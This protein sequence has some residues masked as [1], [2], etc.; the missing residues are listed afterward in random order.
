MPS[1]KDRLAFR[2]LLGLIALPPQV[3]A[4]L[5]VLIIPDAETPLLD[6]D[7][8]NAVLGAGAHPLFL[9]LDL[10]P[11]SPDIHYK[12]EYQ[13]EP[14]QS[15][16]LWLELSS[17]PP[18]VK[19]F[20]FATGAVG[21]VLSPAIRQENGDEEWLISAPGE[22]RLTGVEASLLIEGEANGVASMRLTPT[23][24]GIDGVV[25][26]MLDPSMVLIGDTGFGIE[27]PSGI[28]IDQSTV[29]AGIGAL[30]PADG[31]D[32]RGTTVPL[33]RFYLP[34]GVPFIGGHAIDARFSIGESPTPGIDL[35]LSASVPATDTRPRIDI[36][37]ECHDPAATGLTGFVP[38]LVEA[39]MTLPLNGTDVEVSGQPL[40]LL[41]GEPVVARARFSRG[42][43]D[44]KG[45]TRISLAVEGQ[46]PD[47]LLS[48]NAANGGAAAKGMVAVSALATAI[49]ADAKVGHDGVNGG[50]TFFALIGFGAG[51]QGLA[52]FLE[53]RG[54]RFVL[55]SAELE[56]QGPGLP[57]GGA[58]RFI[59]D[60]TASMAIKEF[61]LGPLGIKPDTNRPLRIRVR[62]V[63]LAINIAQ[64]GLKQFELDFDRAD[65][66]IEDPGGWQVTGLDDL[67]DILGT[68]GGRGSMWLEVDLGFKLN[69]G[70][71]KVSGATIRATLGEDGEVSATIRGLDVSLDVAR[72]IEGHGALALTD[73]GFRAALAA[74]IRPLNGLGASASLEY[75]PPMVNLA[76]GVDLPGPI[77]IANTGLGLYGLGGVFSVN[78]KPNVDAGNIDSQLLWNP[79]MEGAFSQD[80]G[81]FTFGIELV[82]GTAPDLG[83][84]FSA[85]GGIFLTLPDI[86]V[87][88][89]LDGRVMRPRA[90]I[91]ER[92]EPDPQGLSLRGVIAVD[93]A[94][95]VTFALKGAYKVP[96]I[97]SA[98]VPIAARF[99]FD[100]ADNWFIYIGSDGF[101]DG[102]GRGVGP[103]RIEILPDIMPVRADG[104]LMLRG[105]GMPFW[106]R[107]KGAP[108]GGDGFALAFG[109]S[110]LTSVGIRPIVWVEMHASADIRIGTRPLVLAGFGEAGGSLNLGPFSIGVDARLSFVIA[111]DAK[112]YF[113]AQLCGHI[114]LFFFDVEGCVAISINNEPPLTLAPPSL[115]PLDRLEGD[116]VTGHLGLL[117]DD[118][119]TTVAKLATDTASAPTV[120][121]DTLIHFAFAVTPELDPAFHIDQFPGAEKYPEGVRPLP[122]GSEMMQY[123]WHLTNLVLLDVTDNPEGTPVPGSFA[124]AWQYGKSGDAGK[125]CEA[126]ELVL[127]TPRRDLWIDKLADAGEGL[128]HDPIVSEANIC[129]GEEVPLAGW[130][131]GFGS[132][133]IPDGFH[134]P[135]DQQSINPLQSIFSADAFPGYSAW[136]GVPLD[137][138]SVQD[139]A[140]PF[141]F[142]PPRL[143]DLRPPPP[144]EERNFHAV[145]YPGFVGL[146]DLEGGMQMPPRMRLDITLTDRISAGR[147]WI[148]SNISLQDA[149][150][151]PCVVQD[152]RVRSFWEITDEKA[153]GEG[154]FA[155]RFAQRRQGEFTKLLIEWAPN[156]EV[157]VLGIGGITATARAAATARNAARAAE[158]A[159]RAA[160]AD[161]HPP[162]PDAP[163]S[164]L[165]RC[166]L[167]PGKVYRVDIDLQWTGS[168]SRQNDMG[169][170][171]TVH[172]INELQAAYKPSGPDGPDVPTLRRFFFRTAPVPTVHAG[173]GAAA[174]ILP[175]YLTETW[176]SAIYRKQDLFDPQMLSRHLLGYEPEQTETARFRKDPLRAHFAVAHVGGLADAYGYEL[177][178]GA[179]RVDAAGDDGMPFDIPI[180][181]TALMAPDLLGDADKRRYTLYSS[182]DCKL[183]TPGV[184]LEGKTDLA[185]EAWYEVFAKV[186]PKPGVDVA[187]SGLPGVTFKTSRWLEPA[188]MLAALT[189]TD[190]HTNT[191]TGDLEIR[192]LPAFDRAI[193]HG[194]DAAYEA[195][196]DALGLDDLPLA[197][198][199]RTS[200]LWQ[201]R[202][203]EENPEWLCAGLLVEA[204]EP[205][206]RPGRAEAGHLALTM[207]PAG[208][209]I[210]FGIERWD[211]I[212]AR[213]LFLT[214]MPFKPQRWPVRSRP[215][216]PP[217]AGRLFPRPSLFKTPTLDLHITDRLPQG[218]TRA[219]VG[220]IGLPLQPAFAGDHE[221]A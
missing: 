151:S 35:S 90:L 199:I 209:G 177:T 128:A 120:W 25:T 16:R 208:G 147:L 123:R 125:T 1:L 110:F 195:A 200:V 191:R 97:V 189:T 221:W 42:A 132:T 71:V 194:E 103:A 7:D 145:L 217:G 22:V 63:A 101:D 143:D 78:G 180:Q 102:Q 171:Q 210:S 75:K 119:Y 36:R 186:K 115:H 166:M 129:R 6:A 10:N 156:I 146:P 126:P 95:G 29:A 111:A 3:E 30:P 218:G 138:F 150:D 72:A 56:S 49:L 38:T 134:L 96:I 34:K 131:V 121:P 158:A 204:P 20:S 93:H 48:V 84:S 5:T 137:R 37:I 91:S 82:I 161:Q 124:A 53:D 13:G 9:D 164:P 207:G 55:H 216:R 159:A 212:G 154:L 160:A 4:L 142:L 144:L 116:A 170:V 174:L 41:A 114:D 122:M 11:P 185:A 65:L 68:R 87:R 181:W 69:L 168:L 40:E 153:I 59:L 155:V 23:F 86:A 100:H 198:R 148:L 67:F 24:G 202:E 219:L 43:S 12:I 220:H 193:V 74:K 214:A 192:R 83:F 175:D 99:P 162:K 130:A 19:L 139:L 152:E 27:I 58:V 117:I 94:D 28:T 92:P 173:Q 184:T 54:S 113:H 14:L 104:Y 213:L 2:K 8:G 73:Q 45:Q 88:G 57:V 64:P 178:L 172:A 205:I 187:E 33:A 169:Q 76:L 197:E 109:F 127:L 107:G 106:P 31:P 89:A 108:N 149:D 62:G 61:K 141:F 18:A 51:L 80:N 60:Y 140:P 70:P 118:H 50:V 201:R 211:R 163:P 105:A 32:W 157:G 133:R 112:P 44:P 203:T 135:P 77:P 182:S 17:I 85:K 188:D 47:G 21:M 165:I 176:L 79:Q 206:H 183:P 190:E 167:Q 39:A 98:T 179:R 215:S 66:E 81:A 46:G 136:P 15:F 26:L 52:R 196:L